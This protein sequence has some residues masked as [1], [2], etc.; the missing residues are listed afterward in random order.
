MMTDL[1]M[2]YVRWFWLTLGGLLL[3]AEMLG[4]GGYLLWSGVSALLVG[5]LVWLLPL[6]LPAQ[7]VAFALLTVLTACLWWYWLR[8]RT[9]RGPASTLNQRGLQLVGRKANLS[10]PVVNGSG[11]IILGD[12][13]WRVTA[14][15]DLPAGTPVE[16]VAIEG[17]TLR[18]RPQTR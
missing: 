14:D 3:A 18:V 10:E 15:G 8:Q 9:L 2:T 12:S 11:R 13:S 5:V 17:I 7:G 6:G 1:L 16:I 4:A